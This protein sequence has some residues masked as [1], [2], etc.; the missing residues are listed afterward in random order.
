MEKR[1][2]SGSVPGKRATIQR[3]LLLDLIEQAGRH[4]DADDL[5][6]RA[7]E[8]GHSISLSTVYRNLKLF[9]EF[10][11]IE[12]RHFAEEHHHY[13]AKAIAKHHH[14]VCLSCGEVI[15]FKSPLIERMKGQLGKQKD[16]VV[17]EAEVRM[18]G[19]CARCQQSGASKYAE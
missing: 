16:F 10:G 9:K 19:Y 18:T 1:S 15:E 5:Y 7:R 14:L 12:E 6:R 3:K 17:T 8:Q 2:S 11:L 13:E 4:L